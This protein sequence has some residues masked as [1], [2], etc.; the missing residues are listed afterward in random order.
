[1]LAVLGTLDTMAS[2]PKRQLASAALMRCRLQALRGEANEPDAW[3]AQVDAALQGRSDLV[4]VYACLRAAEA[5]WL[6]GDTPALLHWVQQGL[7]HAD[8]PWQ[9]GQLRQWWRRAG[10][11]LPAAPAPLALPH[12]AAEAGD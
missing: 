12:R 10:S 9:Q 7:A 8:G 11:A 3:A 4:P 6:R 5:A 2:V 1:M